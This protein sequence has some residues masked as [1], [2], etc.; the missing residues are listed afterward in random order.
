MPTGPQTLAPCH[1]LGGAG[2]PFSTAPSSP[3]THHPVHVKRGRRLEAVAYCNPVLDQSQPPSAT[4]SG[5]SLPPSIRD[6]VSPSG[7][8]WGAFREVSILHSMANN[9]PGW[10]SCGQKLWFRD[11]LRGIYCVLICSTF[12]SLFLPPVNMAIST[13]G[14]PPGWKLDRDKMPLHPEPAPTTDGPEA[15]RLNAPGE[16]KTLRPSLR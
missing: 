8:G 6:C 4:A 15:S 14:P 3:A 7:R 5:V 10:V 11:S 13:G 1:C 16:S 12:H 9:S 2:L